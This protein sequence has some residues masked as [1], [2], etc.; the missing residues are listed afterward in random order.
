MSRPR[1]DSRSVKERDRERERRETERVRERGTGI[2]RNKR[3]I[4]R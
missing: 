2:E 3:Q 1:L 4:Y